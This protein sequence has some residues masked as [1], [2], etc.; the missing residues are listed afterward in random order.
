MV[1]PNSILSE[2]IRIIFNENI[3]SPPS[4]PTKKSVAAAAAAEKNV[5]MIDR[6]VCCWWV[7]YSSHHCMWVLFVRTVNGH[8]RIYCRVVCA[9]YVCNWDI[10]YFPCQYNKYFTHTPMLLICLNECNTTMYLIVWVWVWVWV[11][12]FVFIFF[13]LYYKHTPITL[14]ASRSSV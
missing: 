9:A 6:N 8:I 13:A 3:Y 10:C 4:Q 1:V 7:S 5:I 2:K 11:F 12:L 14:Y